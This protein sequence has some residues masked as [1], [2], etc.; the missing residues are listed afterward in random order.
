MTIGASNVGTPMVLRHAGGG[1]GPGGGPVM[2]DIIGRILAVDDT[3]VTIE[4]RDGSVVS[5]GESAIG[6][7]VVTGEGPASAVSSPHPRPAGGPCDAHHRREPALGRST[8]RVQDLPAD[9]SR[10]HR[11]PALYAPYGFRD[12]HEW[13]YLTPPR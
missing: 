1:I 3:V 9:N 4:R 10:M 2:S 13:R 5:V 8:W 12:H 7:I 6:R 11:R